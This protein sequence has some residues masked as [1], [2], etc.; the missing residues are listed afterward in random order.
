MLTVSIPTKNPKTPVLDAR[1]S[2][3]KATKRPCVD[4]KVLEEDSPAVLQS[5]GNMRLSFHIH[6]CI[7][8]VPFNIVKCRIPGHQFIPILHILPFSKNTISNNIR[9]ASITWWLDILCLT[10]KNPSVHFFTIKIHV[11]LRQDSEYQNIAPAP[12]LCCRISWVYREAFASPADPEGTLA[13]MM[14]TNFW[15]QVNKRFL[16]PPNTHSPSGNDE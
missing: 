14:S 4:F 7:L 8:D 1:S 12:Q 3:I 2:N 15:E 10:F 9:S 16:S 13:D 5:H 11:H 6:T